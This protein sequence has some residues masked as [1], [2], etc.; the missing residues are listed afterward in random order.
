MLDQLLQWDQDVFIYLNGLGVE[1]WDPFWSTVTKISVWTP[2]FLLFLALF[3]LKFPKRQA[4]SRITAVV[5]LAFF[6][7]LITHWTKIGFKRLRPCDDAAINS[8]IRILDTPSGY[9]FFSGH[10]S[11]SFAIALLAY[12][13]LRSKIKWAGL[14]FVWPLLFTTSRIY[15]GVHYPLDVLVGAV[16]GVLSGLLFYRFHRAI[17]PGTS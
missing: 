2:L 4:F 7:T 15:V 13:L 14:F 10:A 6:I 3:L 12:L 17:A 11:S 16:V 1:F 8:F 5:A 9:S